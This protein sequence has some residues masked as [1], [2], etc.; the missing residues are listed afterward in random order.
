MLEYLIIY[1]EYVTVLGCTMLGLSGHHTQVYRK[2]PAFI[3]DLCNFFQEF[4]KLY[5]YCYKGLLRQLDKSI[6]LIYLVCFQVLQKLIKTR[7]KSQSRNMNVQL[8]SAEKLNQCNPVSFDALNSF[9]VT[10]CMFLMNLTI[11]S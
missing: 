11:I 3:V 6:F 4:F 9:A 10:L 5:S 8:V 7:G 1:C 2:N